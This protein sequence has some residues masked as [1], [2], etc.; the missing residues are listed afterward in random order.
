MLK[1]PVLRIAVAV[2]G[3]VTLVGGLARAESPAPDALVSDVQLAHAPPPA[4]GETPG[5]P[6][7]PPAESVNPGLAVVQSLAGVVGGIIALDMLPGNGYNGPAGLGVSFSV[8]SFGPSIGELY[9]GAPWRALIF[10]TA[11]ALCSSLLIY[12]AKSH[13]LLSEDPDPT[14]RGYAELAVAGLLALTVASVIDAGVAARDFNQRHH[15]PSARGVAL[16]PLLLP[17]RA[18][19]G[20][21]AGLDAG[22]LLSAR[23]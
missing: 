12:E 20:G 15:P 19:D 6:E 1:P 2:L 13:D 21:R 5:G 8:V 11:R 4:I 23:F 18:A 14:A 10:S 17:A 9:A 3:S 7:A 16:A 22:L